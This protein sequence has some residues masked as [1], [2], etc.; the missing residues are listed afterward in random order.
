MALAMGL[1]CDPNLHRQRNRATTPTSSPSDRSTESRPSG[2]RRRPDHEKSRLPHPPPFLRYTPTPS[3]YRHQNDSK[4][5]RSLRH[6]HHNDLHPRYAE[7]TLWHRQSGRSTPSIPIGTDPQPQRILRD[8]ISETASPRIN[9]K[10]PELDRPRS[11]HMTPVNHRRRS[12]NPRYY[13]HFRSISER[14]TRHYEAQLDRDR[15]LCWSI[16]E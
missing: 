9:P 1:S 15:V 13:N 14:S 11:R 6:P 16:Y 10:Q 8:F 3:R 7:R 5:A 12:K 4:V 2:C